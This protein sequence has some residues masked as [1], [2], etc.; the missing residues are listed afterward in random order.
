MTGPEEQEGM[1]GVT[2]WETL[3]RLM[4]P[5]A[6][7]DASA[8]WG[9]MRESWGKEFPSD[10]KQFIEAYGA[11]SIENY[12]VVLAPEAKEERLATEGDGMVHETANAEAAWARGEERSPEL[13]AAT[14]ELIAWGADASSDILC[15]DASG[16][17]P[18]T[19]PV[20]VRNRDD[21]LWSRYDCGMVEFLSRMLRADFDE[22][23][24]GGLSLWGKQPATFLNER[25]EKR[26][27]RQ[28][29]DPWTGEPDPY[30]GMFGD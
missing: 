3:L 18:D 10:Y 5:S 12:L 28:G 22:C 14:P 6:E 7:S 1:T 23:P 2:D 20:L 13:A 21:N 15:W 11:G 27:L 16:D 26:L 29:L 24:L 4:P 30:A 19:W 17:D 9:R 25:E 8:D